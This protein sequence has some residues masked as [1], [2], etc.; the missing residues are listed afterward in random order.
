MGKSDDIEKLQHEYEK[1]DP[2]ESEE[3][4]CRA[5]FFSFGVDEAARIISEALENRWTIDLLYD[6][7][8]NDKV[9]AIIYRDMNGKEIKRI[10]R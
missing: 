4:T 1:L 7:E 2:R 8:A 3:K 10:S 6:N 5:L 9:D